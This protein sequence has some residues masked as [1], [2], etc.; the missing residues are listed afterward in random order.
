MFLSSLSL[1]SMSHSLLDAWGDVAPSMAPSEECLP[2]SSS[3]DAE[4]ERVPLDPRGSREEDC[5][6]MDRPGWPLGLLGDN[7]LGS[8]LLGSAC[9]R[10][11][12]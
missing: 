3:E 2:E 8:T 9:N 10:Y 12:N 1:M 5:T 6:D 11:S 4:D 7:L